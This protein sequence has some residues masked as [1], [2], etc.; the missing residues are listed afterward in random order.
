MTDDLL[1][2]KVNTDDVAIQSQGI[3]SNDI[4]HILPEFGGPVQERLTKL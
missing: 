3:S 4:D 2:Y 1:F